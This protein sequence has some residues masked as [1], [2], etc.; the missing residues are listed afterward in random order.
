M[1]VMVDGGGGGGVD[2]DLFY[3]FKISLLRTQFV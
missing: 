3:S 1:V 2:D